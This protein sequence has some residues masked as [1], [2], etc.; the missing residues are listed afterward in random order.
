LSPDEAAPAVVTAA[1]AALAVAVEAAES[2][3]EFESASVFAAESL[4][5]EEPTA[6]LIS[7]AVAS[8]TRRFCVKIHPTGSLKFGENVS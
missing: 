1:S 5:D 8:G 4:E 2:V 3:V 6:A 7:S